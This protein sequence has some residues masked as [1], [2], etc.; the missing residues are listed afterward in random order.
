MTEWAEAMASYR[1][2]AV[3]ALCALGVSTEAAAQLFKCK[4]PDGKI[5]Y[6]DKV[7]EA[8][9]TRAAVPAGVSNRA[10]AIEEKAASDRAVAAKEES[11]ERLKAEAR[12]KAE[13][14]YG[15]LRAPAPVAPAPEAVSVGGPKPYELTNSDRERI[16]NLEVDAGRIGM[17]SEQKRASQLE[18][19]SIRSGG[20]ARMSSSDRERRDSLKADLVSTDAKKRAQSMRDLNDFYSR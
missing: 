7:C 14:K 17:S 4:G 10:H 3:A 5:V 1:T 11:D 8:D 19:Q 6:S 16:R 2:T 15:V 18:I 12:A 20:D 9:S 13:A